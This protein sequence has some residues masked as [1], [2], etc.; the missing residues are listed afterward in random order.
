MLAVIPARGGSKGV[1]RKNLAEVGGIP[2]LVR[3][4]RACRAATRVSAVAVSSDDPEILAL[5]ES[6]GALGVSRPADLAADHSSSEAAVVHVLEQLGAISEAPPDI[7]LLVQCTA[8][9]ISAADIDGVTALVA[10]GGFDSALSVAPTHRFLWRRS[11]PAGAEGVNHDMSM[12]LRRQDV[13][14]EY[15]ETGGAYAFRTAAFLASGHRFFGRVGLF[16]V[17]PAR[18]LEIDEPSD[19]VVARAL[20]AVLDGGR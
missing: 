19:L 12:R 11:G 15:L 20:A 3:A 7:T 14:A 5:A 13:D 17:D 16:E 9:F 4:V 2:L 10:G 1:P 6:E 8:P 18:A